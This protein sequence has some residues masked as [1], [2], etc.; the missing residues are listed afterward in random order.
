MNNVGG[1]EAG[2]IIAGK[3]LEKFSKYPLIHMDIAGTGML[4]KEDFYRSKNG[5]GSGM[6]LLSTFLRRIASDY[7]EKK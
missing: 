2:A 4:K 7:K 1:R 6:R 3:F 5:P